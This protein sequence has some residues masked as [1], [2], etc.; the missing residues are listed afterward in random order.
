MEGPIENEGNGR[1]GEVGWTPEVMESSAAG[2]KDN[3]RQYGAGFSALLISISISEDL[4]LVLAGFEG[5]ETLLLLKVNEL[6]YL[7]LKSRNSYTSQ[8]FWNHTDNQNGAN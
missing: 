7:P 6:G 3:V 4:D 1:V 5:S 8:T 2:R